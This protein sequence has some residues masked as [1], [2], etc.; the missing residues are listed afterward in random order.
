MTD[1][2]HEPENQAH[3]NSRT[4]LFYLLRQLS[5]PGGTRGVESAAVLTVSEKQSETLKNQDDKM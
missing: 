2:I 3:V 4:N 5:G 1:S